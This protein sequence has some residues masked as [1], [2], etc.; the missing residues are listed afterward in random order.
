MGANSQVYS[1]GSSYKPKKMQGPLF[2][3]EGG[4][5]GAWSASKITSAV[6]RLSYIGTLD[7]I[8][9]N[10]KRNKPPHATLQAFSAGEGPPTH[11]TTP[12][13]VLQRSHS[14]Q[15][16]ITFYMTIICC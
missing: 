4:R 16:P 9:L 7:H 2:V 14:S 13:A 8:A 6:Q 11:L 1:V 15:S 3:T 5:L 12:Q 10:Y